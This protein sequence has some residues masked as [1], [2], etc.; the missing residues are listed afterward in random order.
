MK[1][2]ISKAGPPEEGGNNQQQSSY[3]RSS[4]SSAFNGFSVN[5]Q[6]AT[7]ED[8]RFARFGGNDLGKG[9]S[10]VPLSYSSASE[11]IKKFS[12]SPQSSTSMSNENEISRRFGFTSKHFL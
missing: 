10:I 3:G 5:N 11:V 2:I 4:S 9:L 1:T 7:V 6:K 8:N 12:S